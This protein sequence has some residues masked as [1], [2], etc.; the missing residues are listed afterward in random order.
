MLHIAIGTKNPTKVNA[1]K[2][3]FEGI[4]AEFYPCAVSSG[5]SPQPFSDKETI[6][7]AINRARHSLQQEA[8]DIGIG[9]EGGVVETE[10]GLFLCNWGALIDKNDTPII[11]GGARI[12]L[13]KEFEQ[14]LRDGRELG[15]VMAD[16]TMKRNISTKE[17]A[18]GIFT[19]GY[20]DRTEMFVHVSRLLV[21]QYTYKQL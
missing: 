12:S 17:G 11:A 14:H 19:N 21:G 16:Y 1:V 7:G 13:P 5:V 2:K 10:Y 20:I 6:E 4:E 8:A 18:I 3:G 15:E 9:L